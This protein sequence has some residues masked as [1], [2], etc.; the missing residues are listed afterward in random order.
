MRGCG[1]LTIACP[2]RCLLLCLWQAAAPAAAQPPR[3]HPCNRPFLPPHACRRY[4]GHNG[5]WSPALT[6]NKVALSLRR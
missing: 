2:R 1:W 4:D 5:G 3:A 6:I